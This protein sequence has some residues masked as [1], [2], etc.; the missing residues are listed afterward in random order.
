ML[1]ERLLPANPRWR[2]EVSL[3][4]LGTYRRVRIAR[5]YD[6]MP[7]LIGDGRPLERPRVTSKRPVVATSRGLTTRKEHDR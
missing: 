7:Y 2:C 1:R 5:R 4:H 6:G 3:F